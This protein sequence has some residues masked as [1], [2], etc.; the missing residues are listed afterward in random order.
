MRTLGATALLLVMAAAGQS[1]ADPWSESDLLQPADLAAR[2]ASQSPKPKIFYV[3]FGILYR[4]KHIPGAAFTGPAGKQEGLEA[5]RA[6]VI[7][8]PRTTEV[9][10][11]CGCCP[12]NHCPNI[13]PAFL[14]LR[15]LGFQGAKILWL[16]TS[17][18][19]DWIEKGYP[20]EAGAS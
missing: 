14:M 7:K 12:V 11:Y 3:G 1:G 9:V 19:K 8:L 4:S 13:R 2:L 5:L 17:F 18:L 15:E 6:A 10:I 20:V 16:P